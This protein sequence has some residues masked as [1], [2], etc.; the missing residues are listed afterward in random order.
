MR[1]ETQYLV[2]GFLSLLGLG[3]PLPAVQAESS[4]TVSA[5]AS[6]RDA[7]TE[8]GERFQQT[9]QT[10]VKFNFAASGQL[11]AQIQAGGNV[12]VF[13]SASRK[14]INT[15]V[16]AKLVQPGEIIVIAGNALVLIA[17]AS[18]QLSE[19]FDVLTEESVKKIAIGQPA[20][21]PAGAYAMQ[22]LD[23][24]KLSASIKQKLVYGSNVRQVL[25][26]LV[27]EEVDAGVVYRTD[28]LSAGH[29]VR[30]LATAD[31]KLHDRI[32]YPAVVISRSTEPALAK[33]FVQYLTGSEAQK[34]LQEKGFAG[35]TTKPSS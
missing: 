7:L 11:L 14:E 3:M 23:H 26:Y 24:L 25:D 17:P 12:D 32:E 1:I 9:T 15:L 27:R 19:G 34:I 8:I 29:K 18:S 30:I 10:V 21:V 22:A 2:M 6:L 33:D 20:S 16:D 5:A 4:I 31:E 28:A 13:I 35:P